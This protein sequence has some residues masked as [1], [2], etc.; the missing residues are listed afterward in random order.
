VQDLTERSS[1]RTRR[2]NARLRPPH[3][4]VPGELPVRRGHPWLSRHRAWPGEAAAGMTWQEYAFRRSTDANPFPSMM[5]RVCRHR[6]RMAATATRSTTTSASTPSS[7]TSATTP[8]R[9]LQLPARADTGKKVAIVGGGP[10]GLAAAYQLRRK[11]HAVSIFE[12][13]DDLG[14]MFRYGI[15][16]TASARQA[17]LRDQ[18]HRR[19][20][21][22]VHTKTRVGR[23]VPVERSRRPT[24]RSSGPRL[25]DRPWPAGPRLGRDPELRKWSGVPQGLQRGPHEG[26]GLQG[27]VRGGGDTSI[28]VVS[29]ARRIGTS[30]TPILASCRNP[31][32]RTAT[33]RTTPPSRQRARCARD[34]DLAVR[35]SADDGG[36][37]RGARRHDGRRHHP[38]RGHAGRSHQGA[39]GRATALKICAVPWTRAGRSPSRAP[40]R[41]SRRI[42]SSRPSAR[43]ATCRASSSSTTAVVSSLGCLLPGAGKRATS[44]RATSFG[45]TC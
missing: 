27:R 39:D 19:H 16:A 10:A 21:I 5:G 33:S 23:D 20:G 25:P 32:C 18:A 11:G 35:K 1:S 36:R 13:F 28:D 9:G 26:D 2:T 22:E 7:S 4:A 12:Q 14:G 6:A 34:P 41:S 45:R 43:A 15:P 37:A 24:T 31:S 8:L 38:R 44:W 30:S 29:V 40:S 17:R 3:A 42:S